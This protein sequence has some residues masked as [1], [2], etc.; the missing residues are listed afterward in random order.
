MVVAVYTSDEFSEMLLVY[1]LA[2]ML[3]NMTSD[4]FTYKLQ[5]LIS[6]GGLAMAHAMGLG[7]PL[8]GPITR[9]IFWASI[10]KSKLKYAR[11]E[12]KI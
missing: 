6:C 4:L 11:K 7:Q 9:L 10:S 2:C 8:K 3:I 1:L 12:K 5:G